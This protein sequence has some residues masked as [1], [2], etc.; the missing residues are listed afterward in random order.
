MSGITPRAPSPPLADRAS[1]LLSQLGTRSAQEFA[2]RLAPLGMRP[3]HFGL[4]MH[5]S[6]DEGQSQQQLADAMGIHRNVMVGLVDDLENRGLVE[7]RRHPADRRAYALHLTAAAYDLLSRAQRAADE[8]ETHLLAAIDEA[9]RTHL[10]A[11]LQ[12]LADHAGLAP[13]VHP[14]LR[15][16]ES[17]AAHRPC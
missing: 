17:S 9:D 8:Q 5:L 7:R 3:S 10:I 16:D 13:G 11:L 14:G 12:R 15:D 1:F 2:N 6:Q 4:L